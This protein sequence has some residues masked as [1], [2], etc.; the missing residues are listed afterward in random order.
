MTSQSEIFENEKREA[1]REKPKKIFAEPQIV[2]TARSSERI[3]ILSWMKIVILNKRYAP[4]PQKSFAFSKT[5]E[6]TIVIFISHRNDPSI[7]DRI[8][9][10]V[11][12]VY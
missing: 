12:H 8:A 1:D 7:V 10:V 2:A 4:T 9:S 5:I 3:L 6:S 11:S